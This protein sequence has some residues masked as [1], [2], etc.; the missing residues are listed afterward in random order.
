MAWR[1][2]RLM[3]RE[4]IFSIHVDYTSE[5]KRGGISLHK[6]DDNMHA[7]ERDLRKLIEDQLPHDLSSYFG[8]DVKT[9]VV[10]TKYTSLT[11]LFGALLAA[12]P[13]IGGYHD[14]YESVHLI[15]KHCASLLA[16]LNDSQYNHIFDAS[17]AVYYP[18][19]PDPSD[20]PFRWMRHLFG[21][22]EGEMFA[23]G[24]FA[25]PPIASARRDLFFWYLVVTNL[26]LFALVAVLVFRAVETT[27]L[28]EPPP[29]PATTTSPLPHPRTP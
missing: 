21:H 11:V 16:Y 10:D 26:A 17:V 14:F 28:R 27:Y 25:Q 3:R 18:N 6:G 9:R 15:R 29:R 1:R 7:I 23:A 13:L 22:P 24:A 20:Y 4:V 12:Y 5:Y 8:I 19:V 2:P